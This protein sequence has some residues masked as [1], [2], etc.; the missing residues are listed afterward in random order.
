[1]PVL[2]D[3]RR[4]GDLLHIQIRDEG[5]GMTDAQLR[6]ARDRV[7]HPRRLDHRTTQQMGLPVV[8]SIAH[9]LGIKVEFRSIPQQGTTVDL[10]V[11][12]SLFVHRTALHEQT[13]ELAPISATV[14]A[15]PPPTWPLPAVA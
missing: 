6:T 2:V 15:A 10:T 3:A 11:P 5:T 13:R 7:A 4:V 9:R 1:R 14:A 12:G 8:G